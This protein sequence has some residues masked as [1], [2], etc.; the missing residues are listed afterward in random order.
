MITAKTLEKQSELAKNLLGLLENAESRF[1]KSNPEKLIEISSLKKKILNE[2]LHVVVLGSF[3]RGK[4][5]FINALL[6]EKILPSYAT[7]CTAVIN[8]IKW[9]ETKK[10]VVHFHDIYSMTS[11]Q[12]IALASLPEKA[13]EHLKRFK[14]DHAEPLEIQLDELE[15]YVVIKDPA[16]D[17][18][19]SINE[20]PYD[21]VEIFWPLPLLKNGIVIIDSPGL[22]ECESRAKITEHYLGRADAILYVQ[23]CTLLAGQT[24]MDFIDNMLIGNAY[25]DTFFVCNQFDKIKERDRERLIAY[26]REKLG[27]KTNYGPEDGVFFLSALDALEGRLQNDEQRV[28]R[29]GIA[30]MEKRLYSMLV[31]SRGKTKLVQPTRFFAQELAKLTD[32]AYTKRTEAHEKVQDLQ[33]RLKEF[34]R[35]L[36]R[37]IVYIHKT[38]EKLRTDLEKIVQTSKLDID[39]SFQNFYIPQVSQAI[40]EYH[41]T[42]T[43]GLGYVFSEKHVRRKRIIEVA[44][45]IKKSFASFFEENQRQVNEWFQAYVKD[46]NTEAEDFIS[47]AVER[48]VDSI[49]RLQGIWEEGELSADSFSFD[50]ASMKADRMP[51]LSDATSLSQSRQKQDIVKTLR[52][53]GIDGEKLHDRPFGSFFSDNNKIYSN[54]FYGVDERDVDRLLR[55]SGFPY[56][57]PSKDTGELKMAIG[58]FLYA[59]LVERKDVLIEPHTRNWENCVT[60]FFDSFWLHIDER[61]DQIKQKAAGQGHELSAFQKM[62]SISDTLLKEIRGTRM[63]LEDLIYDFAVL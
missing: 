37:E 7:P 56:D 26:G 11:L 47:L 30:E 24:E 38:L 35:H 51:K 34:K 27:V 5:T 18:F 46:R 23:S 39:A 17:S 57:D 3:S 32:E 12:K 13:R 50:A 41:P 16:R 63:S 61:L 21:Y 58:E 40:L 22:D 60:S 55:E 44:K 53:V 8:E 48:I 59:R 20:S 15:E 28:E 62:Q 33:F 4:S 54:F 45:E 19:E 52:N 31:T 36:E 6:G 10:A 29:S 25:E 49:Q 1:F 9:G 2:T 42:T 14:Q 43:I